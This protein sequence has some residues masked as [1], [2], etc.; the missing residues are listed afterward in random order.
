MNTKI[1]ERQTAKS[2][3]RPR[4]VLRDPARLP[5]K[6]YFLVLTVTVILLIA[7]LATFFVFLF[8]GDA[9]SS[10]AE[11]NGVQNDAV[12]IDTKNKSINGNLPG[13]TVSKRQSYVSSRSPNVEY[14]SSEIASENVILVELD[15]YTSIAEKGADDKIYPASMTKVMSL[16]VVCENL[17]S[18]ATKF[19][20]TQDIVDYSIRME[21]SGIGLKAGEKLDAQDLLYLTAYQSDTIAVIMLANYIGGSEEGFVKMM[22]EKAAQLGLKNTRFANCT[23]LHD[24]NNYTTCR[25]M[26][27]IFA[28]A[29]E[30]PLCKELLTS[31]EGYTVDLGE[32]TITIYSSWY[33]GRFEDRPRLDTVTVSGG[34]TGYIDESGFCLVSYAIRRSDKKE[35]IQVIVGQPKGSGLT[36]TKSVRD[37]KYI[38]NDFT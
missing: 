32:R 10:F 37:I 7:F 13:K 18:L 3:P 16:L 9:I 28:Y 36:E 8:K 14:V 21:G 26:A 23:G 33:S 11:V 27:A 15:G 29:L 22:N 5:G 35:Y 25:E 1:P 12:V 19:T 30:N 4:T 20:V 24:P 2:G 6:T 34:K 17:R 31:Y 38:Y